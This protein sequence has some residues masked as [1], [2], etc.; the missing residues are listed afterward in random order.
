MSVWLAVGLVE[1]FEKNFA[2]L[3]RFP[4]LLQCTLYMLLRCGAP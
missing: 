2:W 4:L 1:I 3:C